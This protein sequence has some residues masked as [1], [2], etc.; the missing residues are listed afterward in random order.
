V[1][2]YDEATINYHLAIL[3]EAGLIKANVYGI[4][5]QPVLGVQLESLTWAGHDFL[6][7]A[8]N[9]TIWNKTTELVKEKAGSVTFAVFRV[10]LEEVAK[11]LTLGNLGVM[12]I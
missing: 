10:A 6:D 11:K 8:R 2:G 9:E 7:A 1:D 12:V 4:D 3:T 5:Q